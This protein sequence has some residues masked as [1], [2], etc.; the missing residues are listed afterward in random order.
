VVTRL[1]QTKR[2][3]YEVLGLQRDAD[4]AS[5]KRAFRKLARQY[6]PDVNSDPGAEEH[7]KEISEAYEVL[8]DSQK[9]QL[10]DQYGHAG[11]NG[12]GADFGNFGGFGSF[13]DIFEQFGS[14]FN[15]GGA[16][17][18]RHGPQRGADLRYDLSIT[19][20]EAV[21]G[22]EKELAIPRLE[23]C[24]RCGGKGAEPKSEL[25]RCPQCNGTGELRRVQQ[26]FFGQFVN[27]TVC[28]RCRGEGQIISSPC[29]ECHG[30][31]R[32]H[33][34]K[35]LSVKIPPGVDND[36]QIRVSGEGEAGPKGGTSGNL[37]VVLAVKPHA[38]FKRDGADI[39]YELLL[40]F[41]QAALGDQVDV[42]TIDG[43]ERL[44]IP[45]GT[46]TGRSFRLRDKGVP[47]LRS[48]GRGD[49]YVTV[50]VRTP[51]SLST[52]ERE[53]YD[54]L[55]TLSRA[56]SGEGHDRGFFAKVKD[57]LGI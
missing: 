16:A 35:R 27:V 39:H 7:F 25:K 13:S 41:P 4:D 36:Q 50:T 49:Q 2:D 44:T 53:L 37:Y 31:G 46:Q 28:N 15:P 19:F 3:Y 20:E 48:M 24:V 9:R 55:A 51:S 47:R 34:T 45:A 30:E 10:Y 11:V 52:R 57:S 5:L 17:S 54:E 23:T 12:A 43:Q 6:H 56:Q 8:N 29:K 32:V 38:F 33:S 42:P 1:A 18:G 14:I 22:C 40:S 26:S 21:F